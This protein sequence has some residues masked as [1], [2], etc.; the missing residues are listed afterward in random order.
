MRIGFTERG[1]AGLDHS[2]KDRLSGLDGAVIITKNANPAFAK[3]LLAAHADH[4]G[5]I[6]LHAGCT[7]LG[8]TIIE[9]NVPAC[10]RQ[11]DYVSRIVDGGFPLD[12]VVIRV[13]PI[14]PIPE[15]LAMAAR[16]IDGAKARG[17]L[18]VDGGARL[19]IS[20]YDE[21][22]HVRERFARAGIAPVYAD[23]SF[24]ADDDQKA[25]VLDM[26]KEHAGDL[27]IETCA[28]P[29]LVRDAG[30][31]GLDVVARGCLSAADLDL[32]GIDAEKAP[33]ATNAQMRRGCLCL[34]CKAELLQNRRQCPHKCL[35]C[36]WRDDA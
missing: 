7:G 28:E 9:P 27:T 19:R 34:A 11:L 35:Y 23:G 25:A 24:Q 12:H 13:D 21:Y 29:E 1:D 15:T 20:I 14:I 22:R 18:G 36:Y 3:H 33:K 16:A 26:L 30:R 32:M 10:D 6:I 31:R 4:P 8:S 17:L 5:K 2:W